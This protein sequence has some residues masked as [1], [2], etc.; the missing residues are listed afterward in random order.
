MKKNFSQTLKHL[1]KFSGI[2]L[3]ALADFIGYDVSYLSKW[4]NGI[5]HPSPKYITRIN[6]R[7]A[8]FIADELIK[9]DRIYPF[10]NEFDIRLSVKM[11]AENTKDR[12]TTE[13][14]NLLNDVYY[15]NQAEP[16]PEDN[17]Q[18]AVS[19]ASYL[20][21]VGRTNI[22]KFFNTKIA[23]LFSTTQEDISILITGDI[24]SLLSRNALLDF[25]NC[26]HFSSENVNIYLGCCINELKQSPDSFLPRL[27]NMLNKYI[28]INF[29]IYDD[30]NF[31]KSNIIT[32]KNYF[33]MHYSMHKDNLIDICT[34][35]TDKKTVKEVWERTYEKFDFN[36]CILEPKD[37]I[38]LVKFRSFFY[39]NSDLLLFCAKG[40]EFFLPA[41]AFKKLLSSSRDYKY[42]SDMQQTIQNMQITWEE[43]FGS[44]HID[45]ILPEA[46]IIRYIENGQLTYGEIDYIASAQEREAQLQQ[47]IK[48]MR[49]N[50]AINIHLL[51]ESQPQN[52]DDSFKLSYY[53]NTKTAYLKKNKSF[54]RNCSKTIYLLRHPFLIDKF[55]SFFH[56]LQ[57]KPNCHK[58][59]AEDLEKIYKNNNALLYRIWKKNTPEK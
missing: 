42:S 10:F 16:I 23:S 18:S 26:C 38:E 28:N 52:E 51:S 50:P 32:V 34:Y 29:Y 53:S 36:C 54:L 31:A 11:T 48:S 17:G 3:S 21:I 39:L 22:K 8:T 1:T 25:L 6:R 47:L 9:Q 15:H 43:Q 30:Q 19:A 44:S 24:V 45:F 13:I 35:I 27:Y 37:D 49:N 40:F 20:T 56:D 7:I 55:N 2:K 33:T 4:C 58:F 57:N 46:N 41:Q 59:S 12:L 14:N 5:N